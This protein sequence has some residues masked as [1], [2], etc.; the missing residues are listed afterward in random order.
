M[1]DKLT[2]GDEEYLSWLIDQHKKITGG[3]INI[4]SVIENELDETIAYIFFDSGGK[5]K[6]KL[7][8]DSIII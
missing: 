6:R 4:S 8:L 3:F 2:K 7:L 5:N 1:S